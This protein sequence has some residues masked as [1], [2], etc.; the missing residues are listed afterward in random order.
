[1]DVDFPRTVLELERRFSSDDACIE[2][3]AALRWS[4]GWICPRCDMAEAWLIRRTRRLCEH[5]RYEMSVSAGTIFQDSHLPLTIWF[6][7]MWRIT[8]QK[9]GMSA[10]GF[11]PSDLE[12]VHDLLSRRTR[13]AR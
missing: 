1:M 13:N 9:N 4:G 3:L 12:P 8:S 10:L 7:A 2:Y 6:C 5:C 11:H